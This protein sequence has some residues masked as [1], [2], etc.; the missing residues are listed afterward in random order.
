[1]DTKNVWIWAVGGFSV[2]ILSAGI[3][4][5][6]LPK[7][8]LPNRPPRP[9]NTST[10]TPNPGTGTSTT[11]I[12]PATP[13]HTGTAPFV[14]TTMTHMEDEFIDDKNEQVFEKHVSDLRWAMDLF[15]EYGA[16]LTI[17]S[18]KPFAVA[19]TT[20][21]TNIMKEIVDRGHGVGTHGHL[22]NSKGAGQSQSTLNASF[23]SY[24]ALIDGLVGAENN[25]GM[26]TGFG[27]LDWISAAENAGFAYVDGV[28]GF[29]YLS[30]AENIRPSGWSNS[31][32]L[33]TGYHDAIPPNLMDRIYPIPMKDAKDLVPD[34]GA[35]VTMMS[36]DIGELS[37]LAEGR[38]NCT[39]NCTLDQRD[40]SVVTDD[41]DQILDGRD[42]ARFAKINMHIPMDL[43]QKKNETILRSLLAAIKTYTDKG[44]LSWDTML[45]S[46]EQYIK[47]EK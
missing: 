32:I 35:K 12:T 17:E 9:G 27:P 40:V 45:G 14:I 18:G 8:P 1:M 43:L 5:I 34:S 42:T 38:S 22:G 44:E 47:W 30:M 19:N 29:G 39:P 20:W 10:A 41:I 24:K 37:S 16:K 23:V 25:Q 4:F 31:Y 28:V 46:Y 26:S 15:D 13:T 3:F 11:P 36:G 2:L 7:S 21:G 33:Q 6:T